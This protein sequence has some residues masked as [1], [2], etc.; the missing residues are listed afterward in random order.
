M[1]R[2]D[3]VA[4]SL[5]TQGITA[6]NIWPFDP[7]DIENDGISTT[8]AQLKQALYPFEHIRRAAGD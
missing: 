1:T 8:P 7:A 6:M 5:L 3:A 4:E 2:T